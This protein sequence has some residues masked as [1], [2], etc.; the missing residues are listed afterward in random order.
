MVLLL[1]KKVEYI[2][3]KSIFNENESTL[4]GVY[5]YSKWKDF[6][7]YSDL[8]FKNQNSINGIFYESQIYNEYI[9]DKKIIKNF[10]VDKFF[11]LGFTKNIDEYNFWFKYF[12][13]SIKKKI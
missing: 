2:Q 5:Y 10:T 4:S 12:N 7:K 9:K 8:T 6:K 3:K 13:E 11:S 1:G